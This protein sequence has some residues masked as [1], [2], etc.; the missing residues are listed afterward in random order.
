MNHPLEHSISHCLRLDC[1]IISIHRNLID[2]IAQRQLS[3]NLGPRDRMIKK[4]ECKCLIIV[5]VC[6]QDINSV[7]ESNF[8]I[9]QEGKT[10][11]SILI[12]VEQNKY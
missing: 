10:L 7:K 11:I 1:K 8:N 6:M 2:T 5:V 9:M 12:S 3:G 4:V